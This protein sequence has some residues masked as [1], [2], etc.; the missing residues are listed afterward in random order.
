MIFHRSGAVIAGGAGEAYTASTNVPPEGVLITSVVVCATAASTFSLYVLP[1]GVVTP[2]G[3]DPR[4]IKTKA[5][6]LN[7]TFVFGPN[8]ITLGIDET[9]YVQCNTGSIEVTIMGNTRD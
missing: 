3:T 9:V 2:G 6:A 7:E 4:L 8:L 1:S 5:L